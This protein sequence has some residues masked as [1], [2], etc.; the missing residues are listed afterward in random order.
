MSRCELLWGHMTIHAGHDELAT[1]PVLP[2]G[3]QQGLRWH[4]VAAWLSCHAS[5]CATQLDLQLAPG[6]ADDAAGPC[7][8]VSALAPCLQH[9]SIV[10]AALPPPRSLVAAVTCCRQLRVLQLAEMPGGFWD[11]A[12]VAALAALPCLTSVSASAANLFLH[13]AAPL[14][15]RRP[16]LLRLDVSMPDPLA[17]DA[18]VARACRPIGQVDDSNGG[19]T[20]VAAPCGVDDLL[21]LGVL[22]MLSAMASMLYAIV[23]I[24]VEEGQAGSRPGAT[25]VEA[26][27]AGILVL[28]GSKGNLNASW[29]PT[30]SARER[31]ALVVVT[32][33]LTLVYSSKRHSGAKLAADAAPESQ[34][35]AATSCIVLRLLDSCVDVQSVHQSLLAPVGLGGAAL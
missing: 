25:V 14:R 4:K 8:A 12:D 30:G 18:R 19:P 31:D 21:M 13:N 29:S 15:E 5:G 32:D 16:P 27:G 7:D 1:H 11:A 6:A 34:S 24:K 35:R 20:S 23:D 17:T 3:A 33:H 2:E 26:G 22:N 9:L 10:G 28:T